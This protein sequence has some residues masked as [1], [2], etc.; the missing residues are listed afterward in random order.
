[1]PGFNKDHQAFLLMQFSGADSARAW[2]RDLHHH[3][4][5]DVA[6]GDEI[7][8]FRD[9]YRREHRR[10][11]EGFNP[12][13]ATWL[14][15]G[16]SPR[17]LALLL[18]GDSAGLFEHLRQQRFLQNTYRRRGSPA[19]PRDVHAVLILGADRLEDLEREV[20]R[21]R[22]R[23]KNC[24]VV[25]LDD[26]RGNRLPGSREQFGYKDGISQPEIEG[27]PTSAPSD[28][29]R[30]SP[31][32]FVL[33]HEAATG[34]D[35]PEL[36]RLVR[37]GSYLA[38]LKLRQDVVAFRDAVSTQASRLGVEPVELEQALVGR[39]PDGRRAARGVRE[40]S[41]TGRAHPE[42][43]TVAPDNPERHRILRRGIPY[44]PPLA[45]DAP[46]DDQERGLLFLAYQADISRQFEHVWTNW[47]NQSDFPVSGAGADSLIGTA[48]EG[49]EREVL[50]GRAH[51]KGGTEPVRLPQFVELEYG[52]YFFSPSLD[53]LASLAGLSSEQ[54]TTMTT[55]HPASSAYN[56]GNGFQPQVSVVP[57]LGSAASVPTCSTIYVPKTGGEFDYL[58]LVFQQNPYGIDKDHTTL[59]GTALIDGPAAQFG[60]GNPYPNGR[61]LIAYLQGI[62]NSPNYN[63]MD[64]LRA[65][66]HWIFCGEDIRISKAMRL[67]YTYN[68]PGDTSVP[69]FT[70][71]ILIG[72]SG[73]VW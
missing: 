15:V 32:E 68:N 58:S 45:A 18:G 65:F 4:V 5:W 41:H 24:S 28:A 31:S 59:P 57:V 25:E 26:L 23:F 44:G 21:Q 52:G 48:P 10:R 9:L 13:S 71:S 60:A 51:G 55:T 6:T 43:E 30:L 54:T 63:G 64:P 17:G 19:E 8:K 20:A 49:T 66:P 34:A 29:T 33:G 47:L 56:T 40:F 37:N 12:L 42:L 2:L 16:F 67:D 62:Q 27:V 14:N 22:G 3:G 36:E 73:P 35:T 38:F 61:N 11:G 69:Q 7:L 50:I 72:F 46:A 39:T 70:A 1:V 53:G